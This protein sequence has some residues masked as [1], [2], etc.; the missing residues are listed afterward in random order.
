MFLIRMIQLIL[1]G[2]VLFIALKLLG[3]FLSPPVESSIKPKNDL[4]RIPDADF[5]EVDSKLKDEPDKDGD[6]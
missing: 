3:K 1:I 5:K 4:D 6:H 2:V